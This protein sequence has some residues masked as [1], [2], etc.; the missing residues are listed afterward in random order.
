M[1]LLGNCLEES[2][3]CL[4]CLI[5][6]GNL[7]FLLWPCFKNELIALTLTTNSFVIP[8]FLLSYFLVNAPIRLCSFLSRTVMTFKVSFSTFS[9][10]CLKIPLQFVG[11]DRA[12]ANSERFY[13]CNESEDLTFLS[14]LKLPVLNFAFDACKRNVLYCHALLYLSLSVILYT[15]ILLMLSGSILVGDSHRVL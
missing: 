14:A 15:P 5:F 1:H 3:V 2:A 6:K 4:R 11:S 7:H 10:F 12:V 8:K 9:P 13:N